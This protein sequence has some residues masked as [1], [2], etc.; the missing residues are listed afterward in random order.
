MGRKEGG[1][2]GGGLR[3]WVCGAS[4][5]KDMEVNEMEVCR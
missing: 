3:A 5:K 2:G 4:V 1:K